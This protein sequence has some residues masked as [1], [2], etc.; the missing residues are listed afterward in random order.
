MKISG[1]TIASEI[2]ENLKNQVQILRKKNIFPHLAVVLIGDDPS[3]QTYVRQKKINGEKIGIKLSIFHFPCLTGRQA[4]SIGLKEKL[5]ELINILNHDPKI[6]G[7]IIQRPVPIN[8]NKKELDML[9]SSQ[10]DV[11]G[12]HPKS[13]FDPPVGLAV[14]EILEWVYK[15]IIDEYKNYSFFAWLKKQKIL[16]VGR[17]ETAGQPIARTF[18]KKNLKFIVAH[19]QTKNLKKLCLSSDIII[20]CV[21]K[22]NIVRQDMITKKTILIGVGLHPQ[23]EKLAP[24]YNQEEIAQKAAYYTPVPG[25]VGPVNV[26]YLLHNLIVAAKSQSELNFK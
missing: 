10:K 7:I 1:K 21:G 13:L 5:V 8:I 14:L 6:H 19:S 23:E 18:T 16:L 12:F 24:D 11:D 9:V 15:Q 20:T 4:L 25:G 26:A 2:K 3:S 17:G 22:P